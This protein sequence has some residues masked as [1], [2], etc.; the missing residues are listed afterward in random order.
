MMQ[1]TPKLLP[2][3]IADIF[4]SASKTRLLAETDC[5]GLQVA[6]SDGSLD[7]QTKLAIARLFRAVRRGKIQLAA[8]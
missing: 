5:W 8:A 1:S 6:V 2:D 4:V 7:E 3:A